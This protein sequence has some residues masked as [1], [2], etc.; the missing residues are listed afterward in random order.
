MV[1]FDEASGNEA[2][3]RRMTIRRSEIRQIADAMR[4]VCGGDSG[5]REL[6]LPSIDLDIGKGGSYR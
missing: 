5:S 3:L 2:P 4:E 6:L 1:V